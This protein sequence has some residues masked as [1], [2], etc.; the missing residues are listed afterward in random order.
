[1]KDF[2][3]ENQK[4]VCSTVVFAFFQSSKVDRMNR[5]AFGPFPFPNASELKAYFP[6][7]IT[8]RPLPV[9]AA[10]PELVFEHTC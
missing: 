1:M 2:L 9:L 5:S 10:S 6:L 8:K 7:S 4:K 3:Y